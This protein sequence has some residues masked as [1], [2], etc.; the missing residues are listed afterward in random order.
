MRSMRLTNKTLCPHTGSLHNRLSI[1]RRAHM[2]KHPQNNQMRCALHMWGNKSKYD[3]QFCT[4]RHVMSICAWIVSQLFTQSRN[5]TT[6]TTISTMCEPVSN[7]GGQ[8]QCGYCQLMMGNG[9]I[10]TMDAHVGLMKNS[11]TSH[12]IGNCNG[13]QGNA[14]SHVWHTTT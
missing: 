14:M 6:T 7:Y 8:R 3:Q 4:V 2:P 9:L 12:I 10:T 1:Y 11:F 13:I 5:K